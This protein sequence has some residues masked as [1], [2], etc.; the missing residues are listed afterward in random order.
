MVAYCCHD[1][2]EVMTLPDQVECSR[3]KSLGYSGHVRQRSGG[4]RQEA[5]IEDM[6]RVWVTNRIGRA[7]QL[8]HKIW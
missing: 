5:T 1:M 4:E 6:N 2:K 7:I 3:E 8:T